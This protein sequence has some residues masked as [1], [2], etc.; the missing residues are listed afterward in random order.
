[1]KAVDVF[2][3]SKFPEITLVEDHLEE[4]GQSLTNAIETGALVISLSGPSKSGKTV[5]I[6]NAVGRD[7]LLH[8]T[9]AGVETAKMLWDRVFDLIGTAIDVKT[10]T[11]KTFQGA[12]GGKLAAEAG[13]FVK[14]TGE[15]TASGAWGNKSST[16]ASYATDY[17]QLLIRELKNSGFIV[18]VDDFHYIPKEIQSLIANEIKEAIRNE[19]KIICASVPYHSDDVLRANADLRGRIVTLDLD[20]WKPDVLEKIAHKGFSAL[21]MSLSGGYITKIACEAAGSPQLMQ[22]LCLQTCFT[23]GVREKL[24]E[25]TAF[26]A[27]SKCFETTCLQTAMSADYSST[28]DKMEEGP[29]VRGTERNQYTLKDNS[30]LDVYPIILRAIAAD[31]PELTIRYPNLQ[32]RIEMLCS[33]DKPSGS[34]ITGACAQISTIANDSENN[35]IIEWDGDTDVMDIR[36]P[37]L[38]FYLRWSPSRHP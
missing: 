13:L 2:T 5:F 15:I 29:R 10:G 30:V 7:S 8:V 17:L 3:P 36:D 21:N 27:D 28:V 37:Y 19:V 20:Y 22:T 16:D 1:M 14:G 23:L 9:G 31:P 11:E 34:S 12:M 25:I 4:K 38:L 33:S 18:F 32:S 35:N 6:Q 24:P 26:D